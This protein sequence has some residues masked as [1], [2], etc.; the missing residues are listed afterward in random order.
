MKLRISDYDLI[1]VAIESFRKN[2]HN[3]Y[4][5]AMMELSERVSNADPYR[6]EKGQE[7]YEWLE[8][9]RDGDEYIGN[10]G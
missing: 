1:I 7:F 8:N 10:R 6:D 5:E 2:P 4:L 3:N 9:E